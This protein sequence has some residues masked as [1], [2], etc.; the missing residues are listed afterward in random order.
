MQRRSWHLHYDL[1]HSAERE[2]EKVIYMSKHMYNGHLMVNNK[3]K[4]VLNVSSACRNRLSMIFD[5]Y[6]L[7]YFDRTSLR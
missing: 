5:L 4:L 1:E 3:Y 6:L 2:Q 7:R